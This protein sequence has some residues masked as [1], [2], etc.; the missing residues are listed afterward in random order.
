MP[1]TQTTTD[2]ARLGIAEASAQ[3]ARRSLSPVE[4]TRAVLDRIERLDGGLH[5]HITVLADQA[6]AAARAAEAEIAAKGPRGPLHGI[7]YGLK[8]NYDTAGIRT[9]AASR[10][11]WDHVPS[12]DA[13]LHARLQA[14]SDHHLV[15]V[16]GGNLHRLQPHRHAGAVQ[17]P[18]RRGLAVLAEGARG[19][20]D[21]WRTG[22][23]KGLRQ[24]RHRAAQRRRTAAVD[25]HLDAKSAGHRVGHGRHLAH[26]AFDGSAARPAA[27]LDARAGFNLQHLVFGHSKHHV[28]GPILGNAQHRRAGRHHLADLGLHRSDH[29]RHIGQ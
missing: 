7:P 15:T 22:A 1:D 5:A 11:R 24:D 25:G 21:H 8:D 26:H 29:A 16:G 28:A 18:H 9:T 19:Q 23:G 3:I 10:A 27:Y 17:H 2:P 14:G 4:Q 12:T 20:L 13:T 6:M